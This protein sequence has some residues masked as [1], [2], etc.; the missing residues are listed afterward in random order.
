M[1][2]KLPVFL[3]L[4]FATQVLT[5]QDQELA[6][7]PLQAVHNTAKYNRFLFNP[8]FSYNKQAAESGD[9]NGYISVYGRLE[10]VDFVDA[11]RNLNATFSKT[12][13]EKMSYAVGV[14]QQNIG[15]ISHFG[16]ILNYIYNV[17]FNRDTHMAFG[18]NVS[19]QRAGLKSDVRTVDPVENSLILGE[20]D[21]TSLLRVSPGFNI[22]Y[23]NFDFGLV[24]RNIV[25]ASLGGNENLYKSNTIVIHGM[26]SR[27]LA[28]R[29]PNTIRGMLYVEKETEVDAVFGLNGFIENEKY[30]FAQLG[31]NTTYGVSLG[32][33]FNITPQATV[34]YT[35]ERGFGEADI[36]GLNHEFTLAYNFVEPQRG[37]RRKRKLPIPKPKRQLPERKEIS[38]ADKLLAL[39]T[40]R[41]QQTGRIAALQDARAKT[42]LLRNA[43]KQDAEEK[44]KASELVRTVSLQIDDNDLEKAKATLEKIKKSRYISDEDKTSLLAKYT[45]KVEIAQDIEAEET[46]IAE[47]T[48]SKNQARALLARTKKLI[49]NKN[50]IDAETTLELIRNNKYISEEEKRQVVSSLRRLKE[51]KQQEAVVAVE[52]KQRKKGAE[53]LRT[54]N[55]LL[56]NNNIEEAKSKETLISQNK[57]I[58]DADKK[59]LLER[60]NKKVKEN[61]AL[62]LQE[63]NTRKASELVRTTSLLLDSESITASDAQNKIKEIK[64]NQFI[65]EDEKNRIL[66]KLEKVLENQAQVAEAERLAEEKRLAE[67]IRRAKAFANET[68]SIAST[69]SLEDVK[70]RAALVRTSKLVPEEEKERILS[71]LTRI[72]ENKESE[73][74]AAEAARLAEQARKEEAAR[75]AAESARLAEQARK[76][77][78]ARK[79]AEA[80]RLAEQAR[81]EEAAR[82]AAEAEDKRLAKEAE[83]ARIAEEARLAKAAEE[84][85][86]KKATIVRTTSIKDEVENRKKAELVKVKKLISNED[87]KEERRRQVQAALKRTTKKVE[88][89]ETK[90]GNTLKRI[91]LPQN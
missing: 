69:G 15:A 75:K 4:Y 39:Q 25:N 9:K 31:Y 12:F 81:K 90:R 67:E 64:D 91:L 13:N 78:A 71:S 59:Q 38:K 58:S 52:E 16:G 21:D 50:S 87:Q 29:S 83:A 22:N 76:E 42:E 65:S 26:Y 32:L 70:A 8:A 86:K 14:F 49:N 53:L 51:E 28:R 36:F 46:R 48:K 35:I 74:K 20:F 77:E 57:F 10:K 80:A 30:G 11:P 17:E 63:E 88:K 61:E 34:G 84:A 60:L 45:K 43:K 44:D 33:G 82:K 47:E 6:G 73:A 66:R 1:N 41:D 68:E 7:P 72:I 23:R 3:V 54:T 5:A 37:A 55:V 24:A 27:P 40:A 85:R 18:A 62:A 19:Y 79:A 2:K 56:D 89:E